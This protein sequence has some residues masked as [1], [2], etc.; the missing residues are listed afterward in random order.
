[1]I[2]A[3]LAWTGVILTLLFSALGWYELQPVDPG[4]YGD[5][6]PGWAGAGSRISDTLSYFTIWSNVVV[7]VSMSLLARAPERDSTVR[8]VVRVTGLLMILI[9]AIVYQLLLAPSAVVVGWSRLTD[10]I[11]HVVTPILTLL[12]WLLFGP[13]GWISA[14]LIPMALI[15][16]LLWIAWMLARGAV[17]GSYP[18]DFAN[19]G[20]RGY[21]AVFATLALILAFSLV[22][23]ALLWVVDRLLGGRRR[24]A[25]VRD[26]R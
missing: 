3:V 23:T 7:A 2:N 6:A 13:R 18:Y 25:A 8:R 4:M 15:I 9:T 24:P 26:P 16:P 19:V 5:T 20:A 10:P 17:I 22:L 1:M 21:P 14:R 12:V 11:L